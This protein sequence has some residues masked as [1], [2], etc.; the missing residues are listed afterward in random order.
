VWTS[1]R[2]REDACWS[3]LELAGVT[4]M[5]SFSSWKIVLHVAAHAAAPP[6]GAHHS[7][8]VSAPHLS[9]ARPPPRPA[10]LPYHELGSAIMNWPQFD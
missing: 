4:G 8:V 3:V 5:A 6:S 9:S 2:K 7:R 10:N 1:F